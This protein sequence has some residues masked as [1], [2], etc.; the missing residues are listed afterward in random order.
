[1]LVAWVALAAQAL[2][3][4]LRYLG[5]AGAVLGQPVRPIDLIWQGPLLLLDFAAWAQPLADYVR[6]VNRWVW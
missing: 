2:F 6:R 4:R 5:L 3:A 1:L